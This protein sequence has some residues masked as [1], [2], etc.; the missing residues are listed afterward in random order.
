MTFLK[1][2]F[3]T[4][5]PFCSE[6]DSVAAWQREFLEATINHS[7][8]NSVENFHTIPHHSTLSIIINNLTIH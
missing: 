3:A 8:D 6:L 1:I 5:P 2:H 7:S 4:I